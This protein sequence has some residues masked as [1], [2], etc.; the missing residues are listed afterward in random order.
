MSG[1]YLEDP[2]GGNLDRHL[3]V[4]GPSQPLLC[5]EVALLDLRRR[6]DERGH[7]HEQV[8]QVPTDQNVS[9]VDRLS[10]FFFTCSACWSCA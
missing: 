3:A 1:A 4:D 5:L 2:K 10:P 6:A 9:H 7:K 8:E